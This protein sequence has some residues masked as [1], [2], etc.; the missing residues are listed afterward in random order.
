LHN[1]KAMFLEIKLWTFLSLTGRGTCEGEGQLGETRS[2][3]T[4]SRSR[5]IKPKLGSHHPANIT[6]KSTGFWDAPHGSYKGEEKFDSYAR[7]ITRR[8]SIE[9]WLVIVL[10]RSE[11]MEKNMHL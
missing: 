7:I 6:T 3:E 1:S 2:T 4:K 10:V 11:E 5:Q 9:E 8:K